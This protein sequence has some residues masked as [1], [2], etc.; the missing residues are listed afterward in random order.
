MQGFWEFLTAVVTK[1]IDKLNI[2]TIM[3]ILVLFGIWK[4]EQVFV[5]FSVIGKMFKTTFSF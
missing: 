1:L 4:Q 2:V 5:W 3:L